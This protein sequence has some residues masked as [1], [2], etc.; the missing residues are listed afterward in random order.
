MKIFNTETKTLQTLTPNIPGKLQV[1]V[2]GP[3][4]YD[5]SHVGH[6]KT[7]TQFD[8]IV[9]F[10][11]RYYDV[12]FLMN[13]TDVDDKIIARAKEQ[14]S[15]PFAI[16]RL[17][18]DKFFE[19]MEWLG[20]EKPTIVARAHDY[21]PQII[22]Q[23]ERLASIG[24]AYR[25]EDGWYFDL[26]KR[27]RETSSL[28]NRILT[29]DDNRSRLEKKNKRN[30]GDFV[31]W[32]FSKPGDPSWES[33]VLGNGRPGWH[34]EDTA[35][36]EHFFGQNYDIH[37]G[38]TDLIFPHHEAEMIQMETLSNVK[39]ANY[40][41]HTG[42]LEVDGRKMGKSLNNFITIRE[43]KRNHSPLTLRL[44]FLSR[45]YR[46]T[47]EMNDDLL[48]ES[49]GNR[50]RVETLYRKTSEEHPDTPVQLEIIQKIKSDVYSAL[51]E[52]FNTPEAFA[53]FYTFVRDTN[54]GTSFGLETRKFLN[55]INSLFEV[56]D[57]STPIISADTEEIENLISQ[58]EEYRK[59]K[60]W[61]ESDKI[62]NLLVSQFNVVVEDTPDGPKWLIK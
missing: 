51:Q 3:T 34:I 17:Y 42:L 41:I 27:N 31:L 46:S 40:W 39:L 30:D 56:F 33:K 26:S 47:I 2:C 32:K 12:S 35:I 1:F 28:T 48:A 16:S 22:S 23:V 29:G 25:L 53:T 19:D 15:D 58:R 45:H 18:E 24:A 49:L 61:A 11:K 52:D 44:F 38:A 9:K 50:E 14:S 8:F 7:Y 5:Y 36:T 43:L 60:K 4:V 54:K 59:T 37:G 62:R 57:F 10:L 21:I 13:I 20:N 55:E 6:A